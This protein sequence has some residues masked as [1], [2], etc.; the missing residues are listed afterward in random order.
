MSSGDRVEIPLLAPLIPDGIKTGTQFIVEFDPNSQWLAIAT[1]IAAKYLQAGERVTCVTLT[2]PPEAFKEGLAKLG[3]DVQATLKEQRLTIEDWYTASLTGGRIDTG[4]GKGSLF[5]PIQGGH[6]SLSLKV[7]DLSVEW[8]K[9]KKDGFRSDDIVETWPSGALG[10]FESLT[11][12]LRFN[13]E[14]SVVEMALSRWLPNERRA[15]RITFT[16]I[17]TGIHSES[18]YRRLENAY[19]GTIEVRV[20]E[21]NDEVQDSLRVKSLKG[22]PRDAHWHRIEIKQDGEAVLVG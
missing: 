3:V 6:R 19:D 22:Q 8:M 16:G 13:E 12:F 4:P 2:R 11:E 21:Q 9:W 18:L 15:K 5:E 17:A 7:G 10:V 14:N 20:S 1:T